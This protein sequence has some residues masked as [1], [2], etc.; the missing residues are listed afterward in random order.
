MLL[1][2]NYWKT[3]ASPGQ[4][5]CATLITDGGNILPTAL[6]HKPWLYAVFYRHNQKQ[7]SWE[8]LQRQE[9]EKGCSS[10]MSLLMNITNIQHFKRRLAPLIGLILMLQFR[11]PL[12]GYKQNKFSG[13]DRISHP[14]MKNWTWPDICCGKSSP[15][16]T[17]AA[18]CPAECWSCCKME[19]PRSCQQQGKGSWPLRVLVVK[20]WFHSK[21][22]SRMK[23]LSQPCLASPLL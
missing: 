6:R 14:R 17:T 22:F 7:I 10:A 13:P 15:A 16:A 18:W 3:L 21:W 12:L 8:N 19:P 4:K 1:R 2:S 5:N 11:P 20:V 23:D 9:I